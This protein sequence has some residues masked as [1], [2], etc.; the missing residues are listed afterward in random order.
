MARRGAGGKTREE[1][2]AAL[3]ALGATLEVETDP[4]STRFEGEVLARN[5]DAYLALL[6]DVLLRPTFAPAELAR[7]K[8]ELVAQIDELRTDDRALCARFFA[9]NLYGD[10]PY[11]H[12]PEGRRAA[13][14]PRPPRR[15][16]RTSSALRGPQPRH[17]RRGRRRAGRLRARASRAPSRACARGPRPTRSSCARPCRPSG[18]RIQLVDKPDRQQTQLM[19][20]H[21]GAAR[22]RP[23]LPAA[24]GRPRRLRRPRH[25]RRRS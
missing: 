18:W 9:R 23:R 4:D 5:L 1:L 3:D 24:P 6:A 14:R 7:T 17:R 10:H 2:D 25:E 11:G 15:S 19:F 12:P 13:S 21:P 22:H 20:G 16:R 8:R